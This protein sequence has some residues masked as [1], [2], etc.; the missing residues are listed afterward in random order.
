MRR[1][2][3]S[4]SSDDL[5]AIVVSHIGDD[6]VPKLAALDLGRAGHLAGKIIGH[7]LG[8]NRTIEALQN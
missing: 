2:S 6:I 5:K 1:I 3:H 4:Q 7:T 8:A